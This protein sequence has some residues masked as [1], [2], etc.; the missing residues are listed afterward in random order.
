MYVNWVNLT[1]QFNSCILA[2]YSIHEKTPF[3]FLPFR[4]APGEEEG[5]RT[6]EEE[7]KEGGGQGRTIW[8]NILEPI[9][10]FDVK[11]NITRSKDWVGI[12]WKISLV[13]SMV[14]HYFKLF[15]EKQFKI[16]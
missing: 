2:R 11:E 5:E 13:R 6:Q 10:R 16:L 7:W 15:L 9:F 14:H 12:C 8:Y 1:Y 4:P 3:S